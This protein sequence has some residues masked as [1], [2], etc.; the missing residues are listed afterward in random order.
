[1]ERVEFFFQALRELLDDGRIDI[2]KIEIDYAG[3]KFFWMNDVAKQYNLTSVLKDFGVVEHNTSLRMQ[4][5]AQLLL[6][7]TVHTQYLQWQISGK[8]YEYFISETPII[9]MISGDANNAPS[10]RMIEES[11]RGY[12]YEE[13]SPETWE[14]AKDYIV[15][16]YNEFFETGKTT[17]SSDMSKIDEYSYVNLA[18]RFDKL[19]DEC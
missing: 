6:Y 14:K 7:F 1:M 18:A 11:G 16:K 4:K 3:R 8:I 9:G 10:K 2:N 17:C 15:E 12:C 5:S 19:V 13:A